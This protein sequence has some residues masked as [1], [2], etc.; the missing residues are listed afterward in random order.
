MTL[1]NPRKL[2]LLRIIDS[3]AHDMAEPTLDTPIWLESAM[4]TDA[5]DGDGKGRVYRI[6]GCLASQLY[7][8][9][10]Q[11]PASPPDL[12]VVD[13]NFGDDITSPL[14]KVE[15]KIPTGLLHAIPFITWARTSGVISAVAFQTGDKNLFTSEFG[16][17]SDSMKLLAAEL[18]GLAG[19]IHGTAEDVVDGTRDSLLASDGRNRDSPGYR[20]IKSVADT[21][22]RTAR[23]RALA[24][25]RH[26]LLEAA[27]IHNGRFPPNGLRVVIDPENHAAL[28]R[29]VDTAAVMRDDDVI[30]PSSEEWPG[31]AFI[32]TDGARDN[33][34]IESL[35]ADASG[36]FTAVHFGSGVKHHPDR[37]WELFDGVPA[38]GLYLR[39][40]G[41]WTDVVEQA[42]RFALCLPITDAVST[43]KLTERITRGATSCGD[44]DP[45]FVRPVEHEYLV[46]F[47]ALAF[48]IV[49]QFH[50]A[51]EFWTNRFRSVP[52]NPKEGVFDE[53][54]LVQQ[55]YKGPKYP[56]LPEFLTD[57]IAY[58]IQQIGEE[59]ITEDAVE[60]DY[61][62]TYIKKEIKASDEVGSIYRQFLAELGMVRFDERVGDIAGYQRQTLQVNNLENAGL[63]QR[64]GAGFE[65]NRD[66]LHA[67]F[68]KHVPPAP[69]RWSPPWIR[70]GLV[71]TNV[72][73]ENIGSVQWDED[74][75]LK[76]NQH[77][78]SDIVRAPF[79]VTR[80][81]AT[82][83]LNAFQ[84]GRREMGW[85]RELCI[86]FAVSHLRWIDR[87]TWPKCLTGDEQAR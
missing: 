32:R 7:W 36:A 69:E 28:M 75:R 78:L 12:V 16:D 47:L 6:T 61:L 51:S 19:S 82:P 60:C 48:H 87:S 50:A 1:P 21:E 53:S 15:A 43:T 30:R 34:A 22:E 71:Q 83:I 41:Q 77:G 70:D 67:Y 56:T 68:T 76:P 8:K 25:Y 86:Q 11:L 35:F 46:R 64:A 80:P 29:K 3:G 62:N 17:A 20:W 40:L 38:V 42:S 59:D 49:R 66:A 55:H 10:L 27:A 4:G 79:G 2:R 39:R 63:I 45:P 54:S 13:I 84:T 52:W 24:E 73:C 37:V 33:I 58:T 72:L 26:R 5:D 18:A 14:R 65:P 85:L 44:G 31:L 23:E 9:R 81:E 57:L 74:G